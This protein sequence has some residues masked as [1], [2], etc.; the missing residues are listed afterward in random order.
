MIL[1]LNELP[2]MLKANEAGGEIV[3]FG[4]LFRAAYSS[5]SCT[6]QSTWVGVYSS[7]CVMPREKEFGVCNKY[8]LRNERTSERTNE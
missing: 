5:S 4:S 7:P 6:A 3:Q 8:L 2:P 1:Y